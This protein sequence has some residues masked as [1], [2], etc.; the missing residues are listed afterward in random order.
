MSVLMTILAFN[1]IIIIHEM[2]HFIAAKAL[3]VKVLEF[4]LFIG[5]KLFSIKRGET[6]YSLRLLP[7]L[8][9]VKMEGEDESSDHE[10]SF[11]K[12]PLLSRA[13]IIAAGPFA[14]LA[15]ALII[16]TIVFSISGYVTNK[17]SQAPEGSPAYQAGIRAGDEIIKYDGKRIYSPLNIAEFMYVSKGE[18]ATIQYK[19]GDTIHNT[20]IVPRVIPQDK[21]LL[22]FAT[23]EAYGEN[24]TKIASV[25]PGSPSDKAGIKKGDKIL[26]LNGKKMNN[27]TEIVDFMIQNKSAPIDVILLRG[28]EEISLKNI[29]PVKGSNPEYFDIGIDYAFVTPGVFQALGHSVEFTYATTRGVAYTLSW[30]ITGKVSLMQMVGPVGIVTT[31]NQAAQQGS[32]WMEKLISLLNI[33]AFISIAIGATNLVPFPALDG[34]RLL[35]LIIEAIRRKSIPIEKESA[36]NMLGFVLL[37]VLAVFVTTND[38]VRVVKDFVR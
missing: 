34:G 19:R 22:G 8:A 17:V 12:K 33:T 14:N 11:G 9:Y 21:Y 10:R 36:I 1:F 37:I 16:L 23:N 6:Q 30:L 28:N 38:L 35:I 27:M 7:L 15:S 20:Q 26:S 13:I 5:P 25:E 3:G 24:S 18:P 29:I 4:S 32:N 31:I 2:G